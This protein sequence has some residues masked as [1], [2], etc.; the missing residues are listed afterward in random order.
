MPKTLVHDPVVAFETRGRRSSG[1]SFVGRTAPGTHPL[2]SKEYL[3][4]GIANIPALDHVLQKKPRSLQGSHSMRP[5]SL[6]A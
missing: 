6:L 5:L 2:V 3:H 4:Y 1:V